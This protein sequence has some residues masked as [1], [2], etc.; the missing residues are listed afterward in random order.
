M[1]IAL[2]EYLTSVYDTAPEWEPNQPAWLNQIWFPTAG[3]YVRCGNTKLFELLSYI[4]EEFPILPPIYEN[5]Q[6]VN[7]IPATRYIYKFTCPSEVYQ[8]I[9]DQTGL[10]RNIA[11]GKYVMDYWGENIPELQPIVEKINPDALMEN[12]YLYEATLPN[13]IRYR[14]LRTINGM[15]VA[16]IRSWIM[17]HPMTTPQN[18]RV[19]AKNDLMQYLGPSFKIILDTVYPTQ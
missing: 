18:Y 1:D 14:I 8:P 9:M 16:D 19:Q 3:L 6:D 7:G 4:R 5:I 17:R 2:N 13:D 15:N 10:H 12:P 11:R